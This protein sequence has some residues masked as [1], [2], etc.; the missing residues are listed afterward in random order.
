MSLL[1]RVNQVVEQNHLLRPGDRVVVAVS[2]GPDSVCLLRV[3]HALSSRWSWSLSVA[4]LDHGFRDAASRADAS[5]VQQLAEQLGWPIFRKTID[6]PAL[7]AKAGGSAQDISRRERY[8][9]LR[10][11]A[12]DQQAQA[13]VLAHHLGDQA[14]T[15]LLHLLRGA[16]TSGLGGMRLREEHQS[17]PLVRPLLH[18]SRQT[19]LQYLRET[20]Q[21]F[22]IDQS[23]SENHY[24]RNHLRLDILPL[25]HNLNSEVEATL[26]RTATL[27]QAEDQLLTQMADAA[28]QAASHRQASMVLLAVPNLMDLPLAI[29]RRVLRAAWR[30]LSG[31]EQ[32]LE[33]RHVEAAISLLAETVGAACNWPHGFSCRRGYS[34]LAIALTE[35]QLEP[36][37]FPL[38]VPGTVA[39]PGGVGEI[40]A[41]ILPSTAGQRLGGSADRV[42][43][44]LR[45][46]DLADIQVRNWLPGDDFQPFGMQGRKKLQDFFVDQ[47]IDRHKRPRIPL[48]IS[49]G[50]IVWVAGYRLANPFRVTPCSEEI[51]CLEYV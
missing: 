3:L 48:V 14:E 28:Y 36:F 20:G 17:C 1:V 44:D 12:E 21:G 37:T 13:I 5:F 33:F 10:Q 30:E 47:K 2:G 45:S 4:H 39:L 42:Y 34:E 15:V 18:E 19:I 46:L 16:G 25:L 8:L 6:M 32:D 7:L 51:V 31:S 35:D 24:R 26:A 43:C 9:F 49:R 38:T 27:L 50:Q 23:N 40:R 29:L 41:S 11:V 22:R